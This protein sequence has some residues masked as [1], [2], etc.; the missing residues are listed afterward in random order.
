MTR[1]LLLGR[2]GQLGWELERC[3]LTAGD[4]R[5]LDRSGCDLSDPDAVRGL[6]AL[7]PDVIVNAAAYTAVDAA[8]SEPELAHAVN[9][10]AP[11]ILAELARARGA[12]LIHVSTDYVFDGRK[13]GAYTEEDAPAPLGVYGRSKRAG[14]QAIDAAGADALI[15]RTSWVYG[16]RGKNFLRTMLRLAEGGGPL[17]V[18]D[19]QIGVPNWCRVLAQAIAQLLAGGTDRLRERAGVY[20]LTSTSPASWCAFARRILS[21]VGS[22]CEVQP[23]PTREYPTPAPRPARSVLDGARLRETFGVQLPDWTTGL[24]LCLA[25]RAAFERG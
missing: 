24:A 5:A 20:H 17:R 10:T 25:D 9:A 4:V 6:G 18:V 3:L 19:D 2:D 14:E 1:I 13:D 23:I 22:P 21:G 15:L 12:L 16:L 7:A 11:G 8:E